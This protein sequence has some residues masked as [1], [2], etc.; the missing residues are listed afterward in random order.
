MSIIPLLAQSAFEPETVEFLVSVYE[1]AW[2]RVEQSGSTLASPAYQ[3]AAQELLAKRII[4][5][6]NAANATRRFSPTT[7]S[8]FWSVLTRNDRR[9]SDRR[10]SIV[11]MQEPGLEART[12]PIGQLL[13]AF[14]FGQPAEMGLREQRLLPGVDG[15]RGVSRRRCAGGGDLPL[16]SA[17]LGHRPG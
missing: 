10:Q 5:M 2:K 14:L 11:K 4:E 17:D 3:R 8:V 13:G 7:R 15:Y 1:T 9:G 16:R 6:R 12:L